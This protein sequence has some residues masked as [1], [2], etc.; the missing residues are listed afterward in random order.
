M[1]SDLC[2]ITFFAEGG[3]LAGFDYVAVENTRVRWGK[4]AAEPRIGVNDI[5][6]EITI[7]D[8]DIE[9]S[10]EYFE[11]I[12]VVDSIG[13]AFPDAVARITII[14]TSDRKLWREGGRE[15]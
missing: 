3:A 2:V 14:D 4:N 7:I 15:V 12:F 10:T 13:F 8:D 1:H 5:P 9:E 6:F 11:V